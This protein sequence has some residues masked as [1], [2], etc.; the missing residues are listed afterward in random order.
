MMDQPLQTV[1]VRSVK[2]K[3][4]QSSTGDNMINGR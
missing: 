2:G 4:W 1:L 3:S